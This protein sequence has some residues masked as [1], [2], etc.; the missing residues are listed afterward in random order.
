MTTAR[1]CSLGT[2]TAGRSGSSHAAARRPP[3]STAS[4]ERGCPITGSGHAAPTPS[5]SIAAR[6][7]A[8]SAAIF[9][10]ASASPQSRACSTS[11]ARASGTSRARASRSRSSMPRTEDSR[12]RLV[13]D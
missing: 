9:C 2:R 7:C 12:T 13:S 3:S 1:W 6:A 5:S 10:S 8:R 11:G 4:W